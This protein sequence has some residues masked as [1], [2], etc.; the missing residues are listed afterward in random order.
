MG[1]LRRAAH[2]TVKECCMKN[3]P[4]IVAV[5]VIIVLGWGAVAV[6]MQNGSL[7]ANIST[8]QSDMAIQEDEHK[9]AVRQLQKLQA[10]SSR[11]MPRLAQLPLPSGDL[12][13]AKKRGPCVESLEEGADEFVEGMEAF[14]VSEAV[15][16]KYQT[17]LEMLQLEGG[18]EQA[19]LDL[20][21]QRERVLNMVSHG[22]FTNP[23]DSEV[24]LLER[25]EK[26]SELDDQV[27]SLLDSEQYDSYELLKDS[28]FEQYQVQEFDDTL[29]AGDLLDDDQI[30]RLLLS[31]LQFKKDYIQA[32]NVANQLIKDGK[33]NL[34]FKAFDQAVELY[35]TNYMS[36]A[37]NELT[38]TQFERLKEFEENRF[39][40]M[41]LS[42]KAPYEDRAFD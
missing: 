38:D 39:S 15:S 9:D 28:G 23:L 26:L 31:K 13:A 36:A 11:S 22:Y 1:T 8:L 18:G 14:H 19:L 10:E 29:D 7:K 2:N 41:L 5:P 32:I 17:M 34:G 4:S 6:W 24:A 16:R 12:Q 30:N 42:L 35:Q 40:Q 21:A 25:E 20:L 37:R 27:G 33:K 3:I